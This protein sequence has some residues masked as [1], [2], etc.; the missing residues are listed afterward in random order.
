[1]ARAPREWPRFP[2]STEGVGEEIALV[3]ETHKTDPAELKALD[4]AIRSR[5]GRGLSFPV[6]DLVFVRRGRIPRTSSGKIQR[7]VIKEQYLEGG[8]ER[9]EFE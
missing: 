6:S 9:L 4:Y 1:M 8:I 7:G 5:I 3:V 2:V